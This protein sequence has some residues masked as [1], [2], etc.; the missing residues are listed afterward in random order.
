VQAF[1]NCSLPDHYIYLFLDGIILK[2]RTGFGSKKKAILAAY[3]I[4]MEGKRE[5]IDFTI[6]KHE[7]EHA[8]EGVSLEPPHER[9]CRNQSSPHHH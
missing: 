5:L 6:A 4:T 2:I 9:S 1:H 8:W 3:G 7:S